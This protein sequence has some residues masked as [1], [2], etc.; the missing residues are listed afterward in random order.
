MVQTSVLIGEDENA[1][2]TQFI[3]PMLNEL[4]N[5]MPFTLMTRPGVGFLSDIYNPTKDTQLYTFKEVVQTL[6]GSG[7]NQ[8]FKNKSSYHTKEFTTAQVTTLFNHLKIVPPGTDMS[9]SVIQIDS[10]GGK[11]NTKSSSET[12]VPQRSSYMKIQWQ[13][14]WTNKEDDALYLGWIN[15]VYTEFF[16]TMGGTPNPTT[17][18]T[19]SVQGCYYNYPDSDL[20]GPNNNKELAL[21][22]YFGDNLPKLKEVKNRWDPKNYF[23]SLQSI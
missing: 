12:A 22:L 1:I 10:Y 4:Q 19:D 17:D 16:A 15:S 13:T 23:H 18:P 20:N 21:H 11:I 8:R 7:S 9:Q 2:E 6:N 3:I 14:Y 5:I